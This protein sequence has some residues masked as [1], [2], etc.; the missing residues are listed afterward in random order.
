MKS[1]N[2]SNLLPEQQ[3]TPQG[4]GGIARAKKLSKERRAEIARKAAE[5]R[6]GSNN[7]ELA[8]SNAVVEIAKCPQCKAAIGEKCDTSL[9]K[10]AHKARFKEALKIID[11]LSKRLME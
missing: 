10:L 4:M 3:D 5:A 11:A 1:S 9:S 8:I 7:P 2:K 6:W